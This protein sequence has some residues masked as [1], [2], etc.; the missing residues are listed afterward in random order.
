[1]G[2]R[3]SVFKTPLVIA[4]CHQGWDSPSCQWPLLLI[5]ICEASMTIF[6]IFFLVPP[7]MW[8]KPLY[9]QR[10]EGRT[11]VFSWDRFSSSQIIFWE[12]QAMLQSLEKR[13]WGWQALF[14]F[15]SS[16]FFFVMF[17]GIINNASSHR[18]FLLMVTFPQASFRVD[19][20][21]HSQ[22]GSETWRLRSQLSTPEHCGWHIILT[23]NRGSF[24]EKLE[25]LGLPQ[26]PVVK[27]APSSA[28]QGFDLWW[29]KFG[30]TCLVVWPKKGKT[31]VHQAKDC[32]HPLSIYG[33]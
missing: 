17:L 7:S 9:W 19:R 22:D 20:P 1:M 12:R 13:R 30:P 8:E 6:I 25:Q 18:A 32:E 10:T 5:C 24:H 16:P 14:L 27:T 29:G 3:I 26:W 28:G 21:L 4:I 31:L 23:A 15:S 2:C 11:A 33:L